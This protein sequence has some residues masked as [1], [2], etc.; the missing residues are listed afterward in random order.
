MFQNIFPIFLTFE[1]FY[2]SD[3]YLNSRTSKRYWY[4]KDGTRGDDYTK[5]KPYENTKG[6]LA[7]TRRRQNVQNIMENKVGTALFLNRGS[8]LIGGNGTFDGI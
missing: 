6:K 5:T 3:G 2:G 8:T 4:K 1:Y 7:G